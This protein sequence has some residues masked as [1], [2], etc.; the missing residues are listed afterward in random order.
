MVSRGRITL[1]TCRD[2]C[3]AYESFDFPNERNPE[4]LFK[5]FHGFGSSGGEYYTNR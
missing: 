1:S 2:G 4:L 3:F 5:P